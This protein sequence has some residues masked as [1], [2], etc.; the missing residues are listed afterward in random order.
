MYALLIGVLLAAVATAPP[1]PTAELQQRA[2]QNDPV[3]MY[4]LGDQLCRQGDWANGEGWIARAGRLGNVSACLWLADRYDR[5][6]S[7]GVSSRWLKAA[8]EGGSRPAIV[9]WANRL[10]LGQGVP[11]AYTTAVALL[12]PLAAGG[13][14]DAVEALADAR[15]RPLSPPR[16]EA[17]FRAALE[18]AQRSE[19]A[20][21]SALAWRLYRRL[22]EWILADA[23]GLTAEI[24]RLGTPFVPLR[25]ASALSALEAEAGNGSGAACYVRAMV[26]LN[27]LWGPED[28]AQAERWLERGAMLRDPACGSLL[29]DRRAATDGQKGALARYRHLFDGNILNT[30]DP[31]AGDAA[32][33]AF[34]HAVDRMTAESFDRQDLWGEHD[35]GLVQDLASA[36]SFFTSLHLPPDRLARLVDGD[37]DTLPP[38][39]LQAQ[40]LG[41]LLERKAAY[42]DDPAVAHKFLMESAA[43]GTRSAQYRVGLE[44]VERPV[45]ATT[46]LAYLELAAAQDYRP[47][48]RILDATEARLGPATVAAAQAQ[49]GTWWEAAFR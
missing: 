17:R 13:D 48:S 25:L 41:S 7:R 28:P 12:E 27:G 30:Y 18:A 43:Q 9:A 32:T 45:S 8:A 49:A 20:G 23:R 24:P 34:L 1:G 42:A 26:A 37:A 21:D 39:Y 31:A 38:G 4:T 36:K 16:S 44:L 11:R 35:L 40:G 33:A 22:G 47:A 15:K 10:V 29:A 3:A 2:A 19:A 5:R 14:W 6:N 46:G